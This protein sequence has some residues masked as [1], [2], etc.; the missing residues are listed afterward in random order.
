M[1]TVRRRCTPQLRKG[2]TPS[3][4]RCSTGADTEAK[5]PSGLT[6]LYLAAR[7]ECESTAQLPPDGGA[8]V[9]AK[10]AN[11]G[12]V[13]HFAARDWHE[14]IA[15]LLLDRGADTEVKNADGHT[16]LHFAAHLPA[17]SLP[18]G[19]HRGQRGVWL[20]GAAVRS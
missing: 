13:L 9:Q 1:R 16:A 20:D 15:R 11:G 7:S 2:T 8:D 14:A 4:G 5:N 10:N 18:R 12:T 3:S 17:T 19:R 6:A